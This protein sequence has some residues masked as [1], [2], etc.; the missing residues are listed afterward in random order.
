MGTK[1]YKITSRY[2]VRG[3]YQPV[4]QTG[5]VSG[6]PLFWLQMLYAAHLGLETGTRNVGRETEPR[7]LSATRSSTE[8]WS[9][10]PGRC[11][12]QRLG[13]AGE[14]NGPCSSQT[15][16][17]AVP[18]SLSAWKWCV[19]MMRPAGKIRSGAYFWSK[20]ETSFVSKETSG[21]S[22]CI[23]FLGQP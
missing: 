12:G 10:E 21:N 5:W 17:E 20:L 11:Q 18:G 6:E 23:S 7:A 3:G 14:G 13:W 19:V 16:A 15:R 22:R 2:G 4:P 8:P 9:G 1:G